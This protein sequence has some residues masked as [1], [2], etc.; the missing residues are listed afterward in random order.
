M[1]TEK[2]AVKIAQNYVSKQSF[3]K[4]VEISKTKV[5]DRKEFWEVW[6]QRKQP[7]GV[8]IMPRPAHV[9]VTVN[10]ASGI[11]TWEPIE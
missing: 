3:R 8:L 5:Y 4:E 1:V 2:Q 10:K 9:V 11:P 7:R 6:F